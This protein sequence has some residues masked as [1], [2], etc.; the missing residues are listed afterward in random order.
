M[1]IQRLITALILLFLFLGTLFAQSPLA[2]MAFCGVAILIAAWEWSG[3]AELQFVSHK[4]VY[5]AFMALACVDIAWL[6]G[7]ISFD[8][9]VAAM[10]LQLL[11]KLFYFAGAF[12]LGVLGLLLAYPASQK[13]WAAK[14]TRLLFGVILLMSAWAAILYLRNHSYG[15]FWVIY[16]VAVVAAA[17]VGAYFVGKAIGRRKLAPAV[18]P[19]KS[20]EGFIGGVL[21]SQL[22]A[23]ALVLFFAD[24]A[25]SPLPELW[26]LLLV[27]ALLAGVSVLGDLFESM[28]KRS[29]GL[30]DSG[31]ILPGHGGVLDRI[32]GLTAALPIF[33]LLSISLGW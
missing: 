13:I 23:F 16:I 26:M 30:K 8:G 9:E 1:L 33:A 15:Q 32:D 25:D 18:S 29:C 19:G 7:A 28:L 10:N 17:D 11:I 6:S 2:F 31:T 20:W 14:I 22:F 3:F 5:V 27:T 4:I 12:W 21:A 24:R